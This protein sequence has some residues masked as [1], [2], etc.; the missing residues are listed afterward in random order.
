MKRCLHF[1]GLFVIF[2]NLIDGTF[3]AKLAAG[4]DTNMHFAW[5]TGRTFLNYCFLT[6]QRQLLP[7]N[8]SRQEPG[9]P[10]VTSVNDAEA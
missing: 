10:P 5:F 6:I 1:W 7:S 4:V 9:Q 8:Q 2:K 3:L